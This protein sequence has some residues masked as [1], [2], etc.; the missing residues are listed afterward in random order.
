MTVLWDK[1]SVLDLKTSFSTIYSLSSL[2]E[3]FFKRNNFMG[4]YALYLYKNF[5]F[6]LYV[7]F[8]S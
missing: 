6:N 3:K 5:M 4:E 1:I 8:K 7:P 2:D